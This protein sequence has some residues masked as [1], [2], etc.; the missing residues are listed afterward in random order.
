[1][2]LIRPVHKQGITGKDI[3]GET[4]LYDVK[5]DAI[6]ALNPTAQL[7]WELCNGDHSTEDM[8]LSIKDHFS[9]DDTQDV[10]GDIRRTLEIFAEKGLLQDLT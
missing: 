8:E 9:V 6:H 10:S 4:L 7:I 2:N 5:G 1:M 3:G